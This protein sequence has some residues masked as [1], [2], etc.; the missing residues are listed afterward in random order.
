MNNEETIRNEEIISIEEIVDVLKKR[1]KMIVCL[2]LIA[3]IAATIVSFFLITPKYEA[4]T[5][6]FIGKESDKNQSY[7]NNDVQMYQKLLKT[8]AE[9]VTTNDLVE[10]A[11]DRNNLNISSEAV[12]KGLTV[13]PRADTQILEIK[14]T[15]TN[16]ELAKSVI[17]SITDEF[18]IDS[19]EL[20]SNGN[21]KVV[22]SVKLPEAPSSPNKKLN[23]VI[24]L[25]A[26]LMV[27]IGIAYLLEF[28][29]DTFKTKEQLEEILGLPVIG[30]IPD[31][32]S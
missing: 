27:G 20:I 21:V 19:K 7:D 24:A 29:D 14:Y 6:V 28:V 9:I 26:G 17:E 15:S 30:T 2:A 23:I 31:D 10:K 4:S 11:V 5:K 1:W 16:P 13:T 12:L 22:E 18:I 32:L 8:Y 3:T 25:M